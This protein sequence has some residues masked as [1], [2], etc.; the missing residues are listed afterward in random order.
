LVIAT[1]QYN[2]NLNPQTVYR[3]PLL[4]SQLHYEQCKH[5]GTFPL[6][7]LMFGVSCLQAVQNSI[8]FNF[9]LFV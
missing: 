1:E 8:N 4:M 7:V 5:Y 2:Y 3:L 6:H 9:V